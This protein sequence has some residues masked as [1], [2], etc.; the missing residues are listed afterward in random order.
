MKVI[1]SQWI[2]VIL[3][4]A[5]YPKYAAHGQLFI[6]EFLASNASVNTDP[7]FSENADW[8]ELFNAGNTPVN[9]NGYFLTDNLDNPDKWFINAELIIPAKG[10]AL[11]W[12]DGMDTGTHTNYRI[13]QEGEEIGLFSPGYQLLDSVTFGSQMTD[14]SR[15]RSPDGSD[16]WRYYKT[17]TPGA[18]N[19]TAAYRDIVYHMT[20]HSKNGGLY[21][22]GQTI[23][24]T[25]NQGGTIRYTLNGS[26]PDTNSPAYEGPIIIDETTVVRSGIFIPGLIPGPVNTQTYFIDEGFEDRKLPVISLATDPANFWDPVKGIY[27]QDFKPDWEVPVNVELFEDNG[28]DR[29]AFNL[30]AGVKINGLYSWKLPQKM[31]GVYFRKQYG[32]SGLDY[33]LF[34]EKER[35]SFRSFALRASGSDWSY[36]LFRDALIQEAV[37]Y[38]M[39]IDFMA[40]RAGILYVNGEYMGIHNIREKVDEDYIIRNHNLEKGTVDVVEN[41]DYAEAG[42]LNAYNE[43]KTLV[44]QD[45]SVQSNFNAVAAL[46]D[47]ENFTDMVVTEIYDRNTS[48]SHNVMAWKPKGNGKWKWILMDL[49]RGFFNPQEQNISFYLNQEEWPFSRLFTNE[50]YKQYFAKRLA[51]HLYTTFNPQRM[52]KRIDY[53]QQLIS[54][55]IPNHVERWLGTTSSYGDAIPSVETWYREVDALRSFA[56]ERPAVVFDNLQIYGLAEAVNLSLSASPAEAGAFMFNGMN[57]PD[58][59]WSGLYPQNLGFEIKAISKPGFI[60]SG[61]RGT[62]SKTV[63][64]EKSVWKYL[65]NGSNQ[66]SEWYSPDYDDSGWA[67]G[68]GKF[69]YGD[70]NEQTTLG[71]GPDSNN[72]FITTYFRKTFEIDTSG[73]PLAGF[74]ISLLRDDGAVVYLNGKEVLRSNMSQYKILFTTKASTPVNDD[75]ESRYFGYPAD[76]SLLKAGTNLIAVEVHQEDRASSDLGFDLKLDIIVF[77]PSSWISPDPV[78]KTT[79][80]GPQML[81]AVFEPTGECV[82]PD[83]IREPLILHEACSP[84]L[85]RG[86]V[87][88]AENA[89]LTIEPGVEIL[90]LPGSDIMV[91]G[92]MVAS[93]SGEK[94]IRF[95]INPAFR[96]M[97]WG[98]LCFVGTTDT[99][100]MRY[101]TLEDASYGP[102]PIRDVAAISAYKAV[103]VLDHLNMDE[104]YY[105]PI[106][107]R[108]SDITLTNSSLHSEVTGDLIN[109]KYGRARIENC[110]FIGN[111]SPDTDAIDYDNIDHGVI[112]NCS[113]SDFLGFNSDG[114]DIG[115]KA[116]GIIIDS[117]SFH[118]ITDKGISVGQQSTVSVAHCTFVNCNLGLGLKD[119]CRAVIDHSTFYSVNTPVACFEKNQGSAG[120]NGIVRNSILSN[121]Y[122]ASF[123]SD[124]KST[125]SLYKCISDNDRL[126]ENG[127]NLYGNPLFANPTHYDFNLQAGSPAAGAAGGGYPETDLGSKYYKINGIPSVMISK[128]F[129]NPLKEPDK[130]EFIAIFNPSPLPVDLAGYTFTKGIDYTF[131]K[132][133][134]LNPGSTLMLSKDIVDLPSVSLFSE[135]RQW[136]YGSLENTGEAIQLNDSS[137]IVIDKVIYSPDAPWPEMKGSAGRVLSLISPS[138]DNHFGENWIVE[139]Y[140]SLLFGKEEPEPL[141]FRIYPN[142]SSGMVIIETPGAMPDRFE[143]YTVSGMLV[144]SGSLNAEGKTT[145]NLVRF[146]QQMLIIR[147]GAIAEKVLIMGEQQ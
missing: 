43:F 48:I 97:R 116:T 58:P 63:I 93:G 9:L 49:D 85:V 70:G 39:D 66:E 84:Y 30:R 52:L 13:A 60:F 62:L 146:R 74:I 123:S 2:C 25:T 128:I 101:V 92:N 88:V 122:E 136:S 134:I 108:Y 17:P 142:P 38:N 131:P 102:V 40:F 51:D 8:I 138:Y 105:N 104:T 37:D 56:R 133:S 42:D 24:L 15:G 36:T 95:R 83:T 6:N 90:M 130:H 147:I 4:F 113:I 79:L 75:D 27:V 121:S 77:D 109:V 132:E 32:S 144:C 1:F 78:L 82:L 115:E 96:P 120:G 23:E 45:L 127:T 57:V 31:L 118:N 53:H 86:D 10:Y 89:T 41:E 71:Y 117:V 68:P 69:G 98:A 99:S 137:G 103:L 87:Y 67:S 114:I 16:T 81:T 59:V 107:A 106:A 110:V 135:A 21:P 5:V 26:E 33:P 119:S 64:P 12:T 55:E 7:D 18:S 46:M 14:I 44:N 34:F 19:S 126:P 47:I 94:R 143:V 91:H 141:T 28:S 50:G 139:D 125:L 124:L 100:L 35:G 3:L 22:S 20:E 72:K 61:W 145:V 112:R 111:R 73:Q 140:D 54:A 29:A 80:T 11:I 76:P 65:D 129:C